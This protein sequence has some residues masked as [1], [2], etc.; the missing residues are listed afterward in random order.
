MVDGINFL[1]IVN[2][3]ET[4]GDNQGDINDKGFAAVINLG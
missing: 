3:Q 4:D 2:S 1:F